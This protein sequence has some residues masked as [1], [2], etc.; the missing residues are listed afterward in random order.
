M[1]PMKAALVA[2]DS[3]KPGERLNYT[4]T[5]KK[6]SI[7]RD[8]LSRRHRRVQGSREQ[9]YRNQQNLSP[10]Q[11]SHLIEYVDHLCERSLPLTKRMIRN[12]A[13][14]ITQKYVGNNWIDRFLK[15]HNID[16]YTR[17][18]SGMEKE[19][20]EADSA[21][22]YVLYFKLLERKLEEYKIQP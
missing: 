6:F 8:A 12:F 11:E 15:K 17:W 1:D 5:A 9:Q 3:L 4:A 13:Q 10:A 2:L 20:K 22:K 14:E 16:I 21:F 7:G 19:R 18:A